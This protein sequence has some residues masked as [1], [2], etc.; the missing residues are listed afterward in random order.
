MSFSFN[1]PA[2]CDS[3][4]NA[5]GNSNFD[6]EPHEDPS[7]PSLAPADSLKIPENFQKQNSESIASFQ[8][9]AFQ[10]F[11][12]TSSAT[13]DACE[14]KTSEDQDGGLEKDQPTGTVEIS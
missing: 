10:L 11:D 3:G 2:P 5:T 1:F 4:E 14:S 6:E 8:E 7:L 12:L 13:L 9:H